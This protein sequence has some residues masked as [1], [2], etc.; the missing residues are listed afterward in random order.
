MF[1]LTLKEEDKDSY[2]VDV[3]MNGDGTYT[4]SFAS[5]REETFDFN[6]HNFQ[7]ELYRMEEQ[8]SNYSKDYLDRV[9]PNGS[10]RASILGMLLIVDIMAFKKMLD[11]GFT[12]S[13]VWCLIYGMYVLLSR[14]I[15]QI[16]QRKLFVEA[17]KKNCFDENVFRTQR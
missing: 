13:G 8:F 5:G 12:F 11:D 17:K 1:D 4:V 7:V 9:Y 3:V 10:I 2:I 6:I 14:G 16:K 15:P